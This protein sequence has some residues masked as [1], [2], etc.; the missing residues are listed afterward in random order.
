MEIRMLQKEERNT[1]SGLSRFV[2]DNCLRN[3][4]GFHQTTSFVEDY[5]SLE[6]LEK[7]CEQGKLLLWGAFAYGKMVGVAGMHT[8]GMITMLYVVPQ[9]QRKRYGSALLFAMKQYAKEVLHLTRVILNATPAWTYSYFVKQGFACSTDGSNGVP[10]RGVPF[11]PMYANTADAQ[12][13][14]K[15][16]VPGKVYAIAAVGSL[17]LA[18]VLGIG[19]LAGYA[20]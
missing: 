6:N 15:K 8:D 19:F 14:H 7:L 18:T 12:I 3:R 16:H 4:M 13:F 9:F 20:F 17:L 11:V 1:A 10:F 5:L 2:F